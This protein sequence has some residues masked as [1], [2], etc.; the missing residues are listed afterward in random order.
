MGASPS[1]ILPK[2]FGLGAAAVGAML[3]K[4]NQS[5]TKDELGIHESEMVEEDYLYNL[6]HTMGKSGS[7]YGTLNHWAHWVQDPKRFHFIKRPLI[8][9]KGYADMLMSNIIPITLGFVGLTWAFGGSV[10]GN[11]GKVASGLGWAGGNIFSAINQIGRA[12]WTMLSGVLPRHL[13][14]LGGIRSMATGNPAGLMA[15]AA[16]LGVAAYVAHLFKRELT[17]ENQEAH[18]NYLNPPHH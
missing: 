4:D 2:I 5:F 6:T 8:H 14:I 16:G 13:G 11:L 7:P 9:I 3:L 15:I 12:S 1:S 17:G 10:T 18:M